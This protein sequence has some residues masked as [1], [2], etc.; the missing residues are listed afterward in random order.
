MKRKMNAQAKLAHFTARKQ[1]GDSIRIAEAT[2]YSESHV[3][4][5]LAGRRSIPKDM[6]NQMYNISRNRVKNSKL[7][8]A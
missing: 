4:N 3:S 1:H 2:G 5:V 7:A 8:I 6:A